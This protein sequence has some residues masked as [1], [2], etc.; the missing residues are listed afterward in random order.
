M[1]GI[2]LHAGEPVPMTPTRFPV[3][4][5]PDRAAT[6]RCDRSR[7][8][9][10]RGRGRAAR[11]PTR[12]TRSPSPRTSPRPCRQTS[13]SNDP[14]L[15]GP[16]EGRRAHP[17]V[18]LDVTSEVESIGNV[19]EV[20]QDL[21]LAWRIVQTTPTLAGDHWR[22][23][24]STRDS[25]RRSAPRGSGSRTTCR[26]DRS[27]P[28]TPGP[29]DRSGEHGAASGAPQSPLRRWRGRCCLALKSALIR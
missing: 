2:D 4:V 3:E 11:L 14:A 5:R 8:G 21:G 15:R 7:P 23:R 16:V 6:E 1:S 28:R 20:A 29:E 9:T 17:R 26:Q 19:I 12:G 18:E 25:R 13:V 10:T 24:R 22:T 27:R